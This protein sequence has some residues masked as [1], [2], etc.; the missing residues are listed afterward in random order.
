MQLGLATI[1]TIGAR[2]NGAPYLVA[3]NDGA[4][5]ERD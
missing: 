2:P 3:F 5:L 1:T 4:H